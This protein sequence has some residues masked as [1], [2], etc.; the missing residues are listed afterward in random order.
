MKRL[1]IPVASLALIAAGFGAGIA[2]TATAG[3]DDTPAVTV[4]R[5]AL[6][7]VAAPKGA[8]KRTLGL[9]RV[10]VMPGAELAPHHH[11]GDQIAYITQG[12]LKYTVITG[13]ATAMKG[14]GD[15]GEVVKKLG[16]GDSIKLRPGMWLIEE[17][18][19]VH[20]ARNAGEIPIVI[21]IATLARTG[22]PASIP[23]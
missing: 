6:A 23:D 7:E 18:N 4:S 13:K 14:P 16:P 1:L 17:E 10:V 12:V 11:A 21:M 22:A 15:V 5:Q 9:S 3:E 19:E 8:P 20:K 2:T